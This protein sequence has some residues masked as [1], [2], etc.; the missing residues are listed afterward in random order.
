MFGDNDSCLDSNE[1]SSEK[2]WVSPHSYSKVLRPAEK[3]LIEKETAK[4]NEFGL[5]YPV[6]PHESFTIALFLFSSKIVAY[7]Q[8]V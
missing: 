6:P 3:N 5:R 1:Y 7:P 4:D 2:S 8:G